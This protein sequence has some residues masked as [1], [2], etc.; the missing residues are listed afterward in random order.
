[1]KIRLKKG[2]SP[3]VIWCIFGDAQIC[4]TK[5]FINILEIL[6]DFVQF[7]LVDK[8]FGPSFSICN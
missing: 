3:S 4:N 1:M 8:Y 5:S 2:S 6:I 7:I